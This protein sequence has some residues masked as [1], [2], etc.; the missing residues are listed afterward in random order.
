[1][2]YMSGLWPILGMMMNEVVDKYYRENYENLVKR[3]KNRLGSTEDAEDAVQNAFVNA[4][5]YY[6]SCT[7]DFDRWFKVILSNSCKKVERERRA[8]GL[9]RNIDDVLEELEPVIP[10]HIKDFFRLHM[11]RLS[12]TKASYNKEIIR[13][14][15]LFGYEPKEISEL[16]GLARS[17]VRN[18][19]LAFN[20]EVKEIYG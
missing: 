10:D 7:I 20:K 16:L 15:I 18:S 4:L 17:T 19:L 8:G 13:L 2:T 1:M 5:K 6:E 12:L 11:D 9:T 14:N 3:T